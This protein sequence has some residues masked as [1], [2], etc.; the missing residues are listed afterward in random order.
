MYAPVPR[1]TTNSASAAPAGSAGTGDGPG[2]GV[3]LGCGPLPQE[4]TL[5]TTFVSSVTAPVRANSAP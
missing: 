5:E 3:G 4:P 2:I 1:I